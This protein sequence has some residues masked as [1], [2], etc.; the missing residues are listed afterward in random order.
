MGER[1]CRP[2]ALSLTLVSLP[3]AKAPPVPLRDILLALFVPCLWGVGFTLAK[4]AGHHFPPIFLVSF[5]YLAMVLMM[6]WRLRRRQT[7]LWQVLVIAAFIGPTQSGLLFHGLQGL[8]ASLA[9]LLAQLQVPLAMLLAWPLLDERPRATSIAGTLVALCGILLILGTP[10]EAPDLTSALMVLCGALCWGLGQVLVRKWNRD[11][12][13]QMSIRVACCS[14]PLGLLGSFLFERGQVDSV[15]TATWQNWEALAGVVL[16]G[17]VAS[18]LIWYGLLTRQRMD[19][20]MPFVLLMPVVGVTIGVLG[21]GESFAWTTLVGGLV[22]LGG[23]ALVVLRRRPAP[24]AVP[25][26]VAAPAE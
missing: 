7:P 21:F 4:P 24:V 13:A 20:L 2:A 11:S 12:G 3:H 14:L 26:P 17:Y 5:C 15:L 8:P 18:Y 23:I 6:S 22:V 9:V 19:R 25:V 10:D 1:R 16:L